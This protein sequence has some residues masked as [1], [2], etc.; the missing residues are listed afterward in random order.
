[1]IQ[2]DVVQIAKL[3]ADAAGIERAGGILGPPTRVEKPTARS[4]TICCPWHDD[5]NPSLWLHPDG[6]AHCYGCRA[7]GKWKA[8]GETA[9]EVSK[10]LTETP[11]TTGRLSTEDTEELRREIDSGVSTVPVYSGGENPDGSIKRGAALGSGPLP[12]PLAPVCSAARDLSRLPFPSAAGS[13]VARTI[14]GSLV[15]TSA[16]SGSLFP[17]LRRL[18]ALAAASAGALPAVLGMGGGSIPERLLSLERHRVSEWRPIGE[19]GW[20]PGGWRSDGTT[21]YLHFDFDG[22]LDAPIDSLGDP[23]WWGSEMGLRVEAAVIAVLP[24]D[25]SG[26]VAILRSGPTG[27][28]IVVELVC[29]WRQAAWN[30]KGFLRI[31]WRA[32]AVALTPIVREWFPGVLPDTRSTGTTMRAP[33]LRRTKERDGSNLWIA[34]LAYV[35]PERSDNGI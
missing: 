3:V 12:S 27:L 13:H 9:V 33:G 34:R 28:Q 21:R 10:W 15:N 31:A 7:N 24:K 19:R 1:M 29:G 14:A 17:I 22:A 32:L 16:L 25:S 26:R 20:M 4:R 23:G 18:D 11:K 2:E 8:A 6:F 35:S 5:R 30:P